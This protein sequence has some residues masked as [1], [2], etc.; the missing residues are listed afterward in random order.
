MHLIKLELRAPKIIE[1][2]AFNWSMT[3][4]SASLHFNKDFIYKD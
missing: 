2:S 4:D 3:D 1:D